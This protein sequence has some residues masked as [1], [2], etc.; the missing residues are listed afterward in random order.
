MD[1]TCLFLWKKLRLLMSEALKQVV[2]LQIRR[3]LLFRPD[4][5]LIYVSAGITEGF[6][7]SRMACFVKKELIKKPLK[8]Y[9]TA[10][11]H[12]AA[13]YII[14]CDSGTFLKKR[15]DLPEITK[16]AETLYG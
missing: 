15:C 2:N 6:Q 13:E 1:L 11:L 16:F 9:I 5:E 12:Y 8:T 14:C 10:N 3:V 4:L 7:S